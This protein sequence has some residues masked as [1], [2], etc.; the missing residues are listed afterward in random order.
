MNTVLE[1]SHLTKRF[2]QSATDFLA[3]DD[4][5]F[6]IK[7]GEIVG[8]LGPNGAGKTTT[9]QMLLGLLTPSSGTIDYF[10]KDFHTHREYALSRINYTSAYSHM[11]SKLSVRQNLHTF[12]GLYGIHSPKKKIE[13]LAALVGIEDLLDQL[14]W[15]L[16][17][18]QKTRANLAKSMINTPKLILMDEPTASLDPEI[19]NTVM[20]LVSNL[21][22]KDNVAMLYTSHNMEEVTRICDKIIFLDH[23]HIVTVDT[24]ENLIQKV[25]AATLTLTIHDKKD[26]ALDLLK[27]EHIHVVL[28]KQEKIAMDIEEQRIPAV[29]H[30][31]AQKGI[32]INHIAIDKPTLED[33][34]LSIAKG[35]AHEFASD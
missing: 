19:V 9:I 26:M 12:A 31:L 8:L 24:P 14:F 34:F 18:G 7:E 25:R 10:G 35:N 30:M 5:S 1:V 15:T 11:Q 23:G 6:S 17:S 29:L 28:H 20:D 2:G 21:Q 22:K 13:E 33:V 3:V 16:S 32:V 27:K 4:I